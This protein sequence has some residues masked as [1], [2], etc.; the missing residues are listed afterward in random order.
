MVSFLLSCAYDFLITR[1]YLHLTFCISPCCGTKN[2]KTSTYTLSENFMESASNTSV[3]LDASAPARR[4]GM[5]ESEW[6]EAIKFDSTD[7]GWVIMSIGM[8][9]GAGIVFLPV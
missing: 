8:A 1:K 7:T 6:R 4:A 2:K 3:I 5:T 9:I